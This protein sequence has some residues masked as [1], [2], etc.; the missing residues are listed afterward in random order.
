MSDVRVL[1]FGG[2]SVADPQKLHQVAAIVEEHYK[3]CKKVVVVVSAMGKSTDQLLSLA[4]EVSPNSKTLHRRELDMMLSVGERIAMSLLSMAIRDRGIESISLTGSQSGIITTDSHGEA[5]ILEIKG[6]RITQAL[7]ESK[8]VIVAGFQGVSPS[9]E[10]TT[11]GRGGSD[12]T[13]LALAVFLKA[14]NACI[15]SDVDAYYSADPKL[16]PAALRH[17]EIPWELG[18]LSSYYGA[19]VLHYRAAQIAATSHLEVQLLS[20]FNPPGKRGLLR[21]GVNDKSDKFQLFTLN[22]KKGL[23]KLTTK[24][25]GGI[26]NKYLTELKSSFLAQKTIQNTELMENMPLEI[27]VYSDEKISGHQEAFK[28][29]FQE[30]WALTLVG[31]GLQTQKSLLEEMLSLLATLGINAEEQE[32]NP[33]F[34]SIVLK[35][36]PEQEKTLLSTLHK[37]FFEKN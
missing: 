4:E 17:D 25:K 27:S 34:L 5:E 32:S 21:G 11:L 14:K 35:A 9:K 37:H 31:T 2:S 29:N 15:Y 33:L 30:Y 36:A 28:K 20:T 7:D 12:T 23:Q 26:D 19:K 1:K 13:A 6:T 8:V 10:I 18:F 16:V 22:L 24:N 3:A